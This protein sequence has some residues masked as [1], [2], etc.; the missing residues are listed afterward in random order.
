[1]THT[2][3]IARTMKEFDSAV[4]DILSANPRDVPFAA[5][6]HVAEQNTL[7][8]LCAWMSLI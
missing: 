7:R 2:A 3:A 8:E 5:L 6:Y 4:I 1:M